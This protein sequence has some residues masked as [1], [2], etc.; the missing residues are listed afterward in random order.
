MRGNLRDM[1]THKRN[2]NGNKPN[3]TWAHS[4]YALSKLMN[5]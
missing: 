4:G 5:V 2:L 1:S 3:I